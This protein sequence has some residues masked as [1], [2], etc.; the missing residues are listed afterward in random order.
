MICLSS[1]LP[2][3][4]VGAHQLK[5]YDTKWIL[6]SIEGALDQVEIKSKVVSEVVY[7]GVLHYLENECPWIP[8]KIEDLYE[9][10]EFL[11]TKIGFRH[12]SGSIPRYS[13]V[14]RISLAKQLLKLD[15]LGERPLL[16]SL[17]KELEI[18]RAYRVEEIILDDVVEAI[19]LLRSET[20]WSEKCQSLYDKFMEIQDLYEG[21]STENQ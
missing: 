19:R 12:I 3:L 8:V 7:F 13:P 2:V 14:V 20:E 16:L 1:K 9:K 5:D 4:Q 10:I 11:F 21:E 18:L 15:D 6:K 17:E